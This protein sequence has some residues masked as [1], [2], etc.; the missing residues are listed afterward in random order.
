MNEEELNYKLKSEFKHSPETH[1]YVSGK[2]KKI[3]KVIKNEYFQKG[4][5]RIPLFQNKGN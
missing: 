3:I 2:V 4:T 1:I 5:K